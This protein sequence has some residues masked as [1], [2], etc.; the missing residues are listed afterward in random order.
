MKNLVAVSM[1]ALL[2]ACGA[3]KENNVAAVLASDTPTRM[4]YSV[5]QRPVDGALHELTLVRNTDNHYRAE[6]RTVFVNR[7]DF[8]EVSSTKQLG[9]NFKC[10][11][12]SQV[13]C[14]EDS[15]PVDGALHELTLVNNGSGSFDAFFRT[16]FVDRISGKEIET[17]K[18]LAH[19]LR[20][21]Q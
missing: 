5:D 18:D 9:N 3:A 13:F 7:I 19:N 1:M 8:S 15:R 20:K 4:V 14:S 10:M 6:F 17:T 11:F 12:T 21:K 16:V 2:T